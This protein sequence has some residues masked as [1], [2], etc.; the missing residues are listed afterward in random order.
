MSTIYSL[1]LRL[2]SDP[3]K[4]LKKKEK[5]PLYNYH[6]IPLFY[7]LILCLGTAKK[8]ICDEILNEYLLKILEDKFKQYYDT[9]K[10]SRN[11]KKDN[12]GAF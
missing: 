12:K 3:Q 8:E 2:K 9:I 11:I 5:K 4:E 10:Y 1:L 7:Q 6:K